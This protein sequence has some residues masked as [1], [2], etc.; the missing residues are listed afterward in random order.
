MPAEFCSL[1]DCLHHKLPVIEY[2]RDIEQVGQA[3][4]KRIQRSLNAM[5]ARPFRLR[6]R[7]SALS[8]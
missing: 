8:R 1:R 5:I 4:S 2:G 3:V 6:N 7:V